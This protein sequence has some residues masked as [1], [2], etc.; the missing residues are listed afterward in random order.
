MRGG[1]EYTN[2]SMSPIVVPDTSLDTDIF[3]APTPQVIIGCLSI[4]DLLSHNYINFLVEIGIVSQNS[5]TNYI[6]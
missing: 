1:G 6:I 3:P 4:P 5:L 2:M